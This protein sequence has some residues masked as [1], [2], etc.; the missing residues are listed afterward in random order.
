MLNL[1]TQHFYSVYSTV[2]LTNLNNPCSD[3]SLDIPNEY[4]FSSSI[5][6]FA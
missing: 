1:L 3:S 2:D 5:A 4:T 6:K